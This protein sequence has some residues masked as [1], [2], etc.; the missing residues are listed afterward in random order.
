MDEEIHSRIL[1][2]ALVKDTAHRNPACAILPLTELP[3]DT[4]DMTFLC[5]MRDLEFYALYF[6]N[7][8]NEYFLVELW[9]VA[10]RFLLFKFVVTIILTF[11]VFMG[12]YL[13]NCSFYL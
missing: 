8:I 9:L 11:I 4:C 7:C 1:G 2:V 6:N 13:F 10:L 3:S 12:N 5:K